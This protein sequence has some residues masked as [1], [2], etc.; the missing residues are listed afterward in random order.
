MNLMTIRDEYT[1]RY[2]WIIVYICDKIAPFYWA[3]S[4]FSNVKIEIGRAIQRTAIRSKRNIRNFY[5]H[6]VLNSYHSSSVAQLHQDHFTSQI[7]ISNKSIHFPDAARSIL[8]HCQKTI[9]YNPNL[10]FQMSRCSACVL[11]F[12]VKRMLIIE[13]AF[14][15]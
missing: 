7:R 5:V 1:Y 12:V 8:L 13:H 9:Q 2:W 4:Q 10:E 15:K 14:S 3:I 6:V 11:S